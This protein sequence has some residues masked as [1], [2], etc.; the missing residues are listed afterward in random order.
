MFERMIFFNATFSKFF[1]ALAS[2]NG[3]QMCFFT[4]FFENVG[5]VKI[6]TKHWLCAEKSRF[7]HLKNHQ[8]IDSTTRLAKALRKTSQK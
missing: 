3:S 6:R 2:Q 7:R 5:L 1:V 4:S 8:E